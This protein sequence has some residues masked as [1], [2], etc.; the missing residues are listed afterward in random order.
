MAYVFKDYI[1]E[2][3]DDIKGNEYL[4]LI[5]ICFHY[6]AFFSLIYKSKSQKIPALDKYL[7]RSSY[8]DQW[9][10]TIGTSEGGILNLYTCNEETKKILCTH[11]NSLFSW[12][13][14][15]GNENPE[16]LAFYREDKTVFFESVVHEGECYILNKDVENVRSIVSKEGWSWTN[17]T[18]ALIYI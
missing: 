2:T 12:N 5:S 6:S 8:K 1:D 16:D 4:E 14:Y 9:P 10:G 17:Y 13:A 3:L 7:I 11:V 18:D 15:F